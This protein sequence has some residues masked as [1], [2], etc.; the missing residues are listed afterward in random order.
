V[1][2]LERYELMDVARMY[3]CDAGEASEI[4]HIQGQ[5]VADAMYVYARRQSCIVYLNAEDALLHNNPPP[6]PVNH[7]AIR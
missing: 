4:R 5:D 1:Q 6:L 2:Q 3:R 7:F